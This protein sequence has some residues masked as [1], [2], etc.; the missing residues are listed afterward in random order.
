VT[1][2]TALDAEQLRAY[3][4]LK[5]VSSLL[6]HAVVQQLRVDA[7]T[8]LMCGRLHEVSAS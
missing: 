6:E 8:Q 4:M 1:D 7:C 3:L 2:A 5:E